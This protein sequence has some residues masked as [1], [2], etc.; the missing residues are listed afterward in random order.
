MQILFLSKNSLTSLE[1][2]Q[3]F[4]CARVISLS[5]NLLPN[6]ASLRPLAEGCPAL[7]TLT[8]EGNPL[9]ALP[10]YRCVGQGH[11]TLNL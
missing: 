3:Q 4:P 9:A 8:L 11:F 1:G 2:V 6:A 5:D 7:E 10:N